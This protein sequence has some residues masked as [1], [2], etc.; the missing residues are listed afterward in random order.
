MNLE[1]IRKQAL[2]LPEVTEEPHFN[3]TSFRV[4]GKIFI[5][6]PPDETHVHIFVGEQ[7]RELALVLYPKFIEKLMWGSRVVGV[8]IVLAKAKLPVVSNLVRKAWENKAPKRLVA[9]AIGN[10]P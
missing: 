9:A 8:R 2:S 6:V 10:E 3:Y 5:T 4:R 7:G 1:T